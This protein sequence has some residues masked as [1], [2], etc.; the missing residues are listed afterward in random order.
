VDVAIAEPVHNL[1]DPDIEQH[2]VR[3]NHLPD[4]EGVVDAVAPGSQS[5]S[6][7]DPKRDV[8]PKDGE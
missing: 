5:E 2:P 8:V 3:A 6:L 7:P 1:V 4:P